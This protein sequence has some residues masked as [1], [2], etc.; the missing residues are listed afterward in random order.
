MLHAKK[1]TPRGAG[2]RAGGQ[3]ERDART[4]TPAGEARPV[5]PEGVHDR[6]HVRGH[7]VV[8]IGAVVAGAATVAAAVDQ[9]GAV[10]GRQDGRHLIAPV[11]GMAEAAMQQNHRRA[12]AV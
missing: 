10:A 3:L 6:Q 9:D 2:W 1:S 11:A 4:V 7:A 8:R 5:D 12:V